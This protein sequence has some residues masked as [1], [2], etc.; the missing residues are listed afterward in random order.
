MIVKMSKVD[1]ARSAIDGGKTV[2]ALD[3]FSNFLKIT[4]SF[5]LHKLVVIE[6]LYRHLFCH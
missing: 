5:I 3:L 4:F 1:C 2:D 6:K